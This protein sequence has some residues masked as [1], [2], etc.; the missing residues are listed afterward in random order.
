MGKGPPKYEYRSREKYV[1]CSHRTSICPWNVG[2]L[3][4]RVVFVRAEY[5][6]R[7]KIVVG[8]RACIGS[9][10]V[11]KPPTPASLRPRGDR[12]P[13]HCCRPETGVQDRRCESRAWP[14]RNIP[15]YFSD[16]SMPSRVAA[17]NPATCKSRSHTY[18]SQ[19]CQGRSMCPHFQAPALSLLQAIA[20]REKR[21]TSC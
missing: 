3:H 14:R 15:P 19:H 1:L 20:A 13:S 4:G 6:T 8:R 12:A 18:C 11:T 21:T 17:K 16:V 9:R 7:P 10:N 5:P 2:V